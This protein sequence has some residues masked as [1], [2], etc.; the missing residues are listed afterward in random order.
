MLVPLSPLKKFTWVQRLI[1]SRCE[2]A[3]ENREVLFSKNY[4]VKKFNNRNKD[5]APSSHL[6]AESTPSTSIMNILSEGSVAPHIP[7]V[8]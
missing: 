2:L 4:K 7:M 6:S 8:F 1:M 3:K 5:T